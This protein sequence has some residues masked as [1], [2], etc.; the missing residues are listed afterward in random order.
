[1]KLRELLDLVE[2]LGDDTEGSRKFRRHIG[3]Q[4]R[5]TE[6]IKNWL[7][8]CIEKSSGAHDP[9]NRAFQDLVVSLGRRLG[10]EINYGRYAGKAGEDNY[11]G[12]WRTKDGDTIVVEVK[13]TTWPIGSINQL[14]NYLDELSRKENIKNIYGL[15]VIGKLT[16][17][18]LIEQILGSKYKDRMRIIEYTDL[19]EILNLKEKLTSRFGKKKALEKVQNLLLPVE[20]I[21]IGNIVRLIVDITTVKKAPPEE[22]TKEEG[23]QKPES[24]QWTKEELL[25]FLKDRTPYQKVLLAAIV[26][27]DEDPAHFNTVISLMNEIVHRTPSLGINKELTGRQIAGTRAGMTANRKRLK[28]ERIIIEKNW[29]YKIRENYK[30]TVID[31]AKTEGLWIKE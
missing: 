24:Q 3:S 11:D 7:N 25:S 12:I 18:A 22:E 1:M 2:P 26:Q 31:W 14:G 15:Y 17:H 28:K 8:E 4:E 19:M 20:S 30:Q 29:W 9:Y 13:T 23:N 27:A 10:F 6:E 5:T 21:N 16:T